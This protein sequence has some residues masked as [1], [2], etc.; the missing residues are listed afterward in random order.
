[1]PIKIR[2]DINHIIKLIINKLF[3]KIVLNRSDC[4]IR[5]LTN[6]NWTK[7]LIEAERLNLSSIKPTKPKTEL[8]KNKS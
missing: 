6:K 1:M 8:A 5:K 7:N 2:L 3:S 4:W